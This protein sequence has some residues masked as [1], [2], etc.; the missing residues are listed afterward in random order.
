MERD[1]DTLLT[2]EEFF[3]DPYPAYRVLRNAAPVF[4]SIH[5]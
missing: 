4:W 3:A 1:F 2:G 5:P